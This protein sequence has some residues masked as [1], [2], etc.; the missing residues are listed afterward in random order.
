MGGKAEITE[1]QAHREQSHREVVLFLFWL[2]CVEDVVTLLPS[3]G[4]LV[5]LKRTGLRQSPPRP[6]IHPVP[7]L[8]QRLRL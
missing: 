5:L 1:R 3:E 6:E 7:A 4:S 2:L 8:V